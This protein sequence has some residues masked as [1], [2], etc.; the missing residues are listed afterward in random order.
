MNEGIVMGFISIVGGLGLG[1]Y[2]MFL[3]ARMREMRHRERLAMIEK[4]IAPPADLFEWDAGPRNGPYGRRRRSGV[5]L[6]FVG[7]GVMLLIGFGSGRALQGL[8]VGGFVA[9]I[10]VAHL[11]NDRLDRRAL[12]DP[13]P[14]PP[15]SNP[16]AT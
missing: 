10:G 13:N 2:S 1:A 14:P 11:V 3:V 7:L 5:L 8:A 15:N 16:P 12:K 9:L 4:G 6:I